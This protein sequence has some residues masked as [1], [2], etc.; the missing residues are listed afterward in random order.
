MNFASLLQKI[1]DVTALGETEVLPIIQTLEADIATAVNNFHMA[2]TGAV[3]NKQT[4]A[5]EQP[6]A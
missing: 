6:K 3:A 1:M 5:S 2:V 4:S